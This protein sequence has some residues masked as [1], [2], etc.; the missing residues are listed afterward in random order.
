MKPGSGG[1]RGGEGQAAVAMYFLPVYTSDAGADLF[2]PSDT[3]RRPGR[4]RS[5][6]PF[7]AT[8]PAVSGPRPEGQPGAAPTSSSRSLPAWCAAGSDRAGRFP[9]HRALRVPTGSGRGAPNSH[10]P[11]GRG[12]ASPTPHGQRAVLPGHVEPRGGAQALRGLVGCWAGPAAGRHP[13]G[14]G[15]RTHWGP[16]ARLWGQGSWCS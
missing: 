6:P 16:Q 1:G 10:G 5:P 3:A 9:C 12:L 14:P 4:V 7:P 11:Q 2:C 8:M 13:L 15:S